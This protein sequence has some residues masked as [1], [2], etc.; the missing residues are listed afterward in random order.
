MPKSPDKRNKRRKEIVEFLK[1]NIYVTDEYL[2]KYFNVSINT[3]R[4]DRQDLKIKELKERIKDV[5]KSSS[6]LLTSL[7]ED[8]VVGNLIEL[9]PGKEATAILKT[10]EDMSFSANNIIRG[11]YIY[12][13]TES[14][15]IAVIPANVALVGVANIKYKKKVT[16]GEILTAKAEVKKSRITNYVVWIKIYNEKKEE[17]FQGKFIL[18]TL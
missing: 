18:K 5:A 14:L 2:A 15:A 10:T 6:K 3:I 13:L 1:K 11:H 9:V 17:V 12:A 7:S 16:V 4:L 8:E